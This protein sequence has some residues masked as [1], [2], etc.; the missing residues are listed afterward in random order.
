MPDHALLHPHVHGDLRI[1]TDRGS[2]LGDAVMTCLVM[3]DEF[4]RVQHE[5]PILFRQTPERDGFAALALFGF[6][7]GENLY[8]ENGRWNARYLPLAM[9]IQPFLIG[10]KAGESGAK[11][12][13]V[14][15][16]SPRIADGEGV[17]LFD[18]EGRP[19][20]FLEAVTEKLGALDMGFQ[21]SAGFF[22][23]L[24]R[25]DLLEPFAFDVTLEDGS[26]NRL[27]GFHVIDEE[28][29]R[30]LDFAALGELQRDGHLLPIFMAVASLGQLSG[31][32]ARKNKRLHG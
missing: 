9:D 16:G 2:E 31:L 1:R 4:R 28:R 27:V 19:S 30:S 24:E 15:L 13:V 26:S 11:Q 3:P 17:R 21:A 8:L 23:A 10:G 6:E 29:L 7:S 14:D 20:P 32:V 12:V 18:G 25:H 22:K 5:Y